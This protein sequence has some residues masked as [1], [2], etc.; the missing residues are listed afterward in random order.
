MIVEVN[1]SR[2]APQIVAQYL[3]PNAVPSSALSEGTAL[4]ALV[5][6][7]FF[8][9]I[10]TRLT[11]DGG[12]DARVTTAEPYPQYAAVTRFRDSIGEFLVQTGLRRG[13]S[14]DPRAASRI[15]WY[16]SAA[17]RDTA[18]TVRRSWKLGDRSE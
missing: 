15:R 3:P 16:T 4:D 18:P 8:G 9:A 17:K 5:P 12:D 7:P 6:N 11:P 2:R 1:T 13:G 14:V 10:R